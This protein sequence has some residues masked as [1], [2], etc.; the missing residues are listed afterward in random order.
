MWMPSQ[1]SQHYSGEAWGPFNRLDLMSNY[2]EESEYLKLSP[3]EG[4]AARAQVL[5]YFLQIKKIIPDI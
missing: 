3:P 2:G 5:D 1:A 4:A